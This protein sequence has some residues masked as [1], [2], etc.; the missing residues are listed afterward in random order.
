MSLVAIAYPL[1]AM[2][3]VFKKNRSLVFTR[4]SF[5]GTGKFSGHW[6]GD[7]AATW[8]DLKWA[9]TGML[10]FNLFGI[11]YVSSLLRTLSRIISSWGKTSSG[12]EIYG[13]ILN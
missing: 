12:K 2:K 6:L 13:Q 5:P 8:N 10:E 1:R 11:P 3:Q 9:I 4:S 7:N